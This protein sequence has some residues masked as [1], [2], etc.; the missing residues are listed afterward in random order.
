MRSL[1]FIP[2][3]D[4]RKL[5]KG[6]NSGADALILDLE[7]SV[8]PARKP[9]ARTLAAQ[10]IADAS[11]REGRPRLYVRINALE[12]DLWQDDVAGVTAA[13]P[14]GIVLPKPRSGDDVHKLSLALRHGEEQAG[15][16][17]GST[18]IIAIAT[19]TP[20]S[21]F[22]LHTYAD[23]SSRLVALTWGGEDLAAVV[24][25]AGNREADGRTWTSPY[26]LARDLTLIAAAAAGVKAIDTVFVN[27]SD[28]E[29]LALEAQA[30]ARDGF[31]GKMAIHPNQ[32]A[33]INAAFTPSTEEVAA[34]EEIVRLFADNPGTGALAHRGQ[35]VDKP[36][37]ARAERT[38]ARARAA[39]RN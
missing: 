10:Y 32:I 24:G 22:Q 29:G 12:T 8:S 5:G 36:H 9:A 2:A 35:M 4:E 13:R 34:A 28:A 3:D 21:L 37:L 20:A 31:I 19:E 11:P 16:A 1:L 30:A 33:T 15:A 23:S 38:L 26:R 25:A 27:L 18:R 39:R 7:D 6:F 17:I 14:D